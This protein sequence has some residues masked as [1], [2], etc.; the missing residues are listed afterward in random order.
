M[1]RRIWELDALR[2]LCVIGMVI[3]HL[4]YNAAALF[5]LIPG[6]LP[7]L[8]TLIQNTGGTAFLLISGICAT[9]GSR[10]LR[11]GTLVLGCG[12]ALT[13]VT[14]AGFA[15]G[16]CGSGYIIWFGALH[17]LGLC[18]IF[19]QGAKKLSTP[20]LGLFGIILT[21]LG[22]RLRSV[23][24]DFPWLIWLGLATPRFVSPDYFPIAPNFGYFLL[25]AV[26]GR[27]LY[28]Q[29]KSLLPKVD[30]NRFPVSFLRYCGTHSLAIYLIHQPVLLV[31][32][33]ILSLLR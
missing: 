13:A 14:A 8:F 16:V 10:S 19:W 3:V 20:V 24:V 32:M 23:L 9:L 6:E 2:G 27:T 7:A 22:W 26:I 5:G 18:M 28:R 17:C 25:G 1:R 30:A 21:I 31:G 15:L 12:M 29:K 11:R 33:T 4:I